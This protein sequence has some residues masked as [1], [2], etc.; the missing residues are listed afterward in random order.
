MGD[1]GGDAVSGAD[2]GGESADLEAS[3][4]RFIEA[5]ENLLKGATMVEGSST[6]PREVYWA[7]KGTPRT[8]CPE[9]RLEN[10][11][12][13]YKIVPDTFKAMADAVQE[14]S[15]IIIDRSEQALR[16]CTHNDMLEDPGMSDKD[17]QRRYQRFCVESDAHDQ[18]G[19]TDPSKRFPPLRRGARRAHESSPQFIPS[20]PPGLDNIT[21]GGVP[22]LSGILRAVETY[23]IWAYAA[24]ATN[25]FQKLK[26][27]NE[28][29]PGDSLRKE[30]KLNLLP[31]VNIRLSGEP[32][33]QFYDRLAGRA[34]LLIELGGA[35]TDL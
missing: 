15:F 26:E 22:C 13:T 27:G 18:N 34:W 16:N 2:M 24:D 14:D 12:K 28:N 32:D 10:N 4:L 19:K 6:Q 21:Q 1:G 25:I 29:C 30:I 3:F 7:G 11:I 20:I 17:L 35:Y 33:D 9:Q 31:K 5:P 8:I 23:S